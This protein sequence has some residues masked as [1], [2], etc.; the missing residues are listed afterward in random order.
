MTCKDCIKFDVC[1]VKKK[2]Y[3]N[4]P[5]KNGNI[6]KE[7]LKYKNGVE[8]TCNHFKD[9]SRIVKLPKTIWVISECLELE[10]YEVLGV[11]TTNNSVWL[12]TKGNKQQLLMQISNY[13][14]T[15]FT[16]KAKAEAKL[17]E[18]NEK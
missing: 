16:D 8:K 12:D 2:Y 4:K 3:A 6:D 1:A 11:F 5:F 17:K 10:E 7:Q 13:N 18:L 9:K 15:W 14:K